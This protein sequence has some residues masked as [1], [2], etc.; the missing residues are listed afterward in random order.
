L[1]T[2]QL[3]AAIEKDV[4]IV[5]TDFN[6]DMLNVARGKFEIH[7]NVEFQTANAMQLPFDDSLFDAVVCQFSIMFFP[8][9]LASLRE[10][11]RVLKTNG[12]FLFNIWDSFEHNHLIRTV[13]KTISEQ[14]PESPPDFFNTPYGYYSIDVIKD[15]LYQAGF[16][17]VEISVL[18][19]TS[20]AD[21]A[22]NVA[23]GYVLGSPVRLQIEK[24]APGSLSDIVDAV[25]RAI[26]SEFGNT[27]IRAKM[28]AVVFR[29]HYSV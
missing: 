15:L 28:Q 27:N 22:K 8:D 4:R 21:T 20:K 13:N 18:P 2:R 10:A 26:S 7:D 23:L 16:G 25:E 24:C 6:E 29:A 12:V 14:L 5:V 11:A 9:K 3:R 17:D 19:R 1:A